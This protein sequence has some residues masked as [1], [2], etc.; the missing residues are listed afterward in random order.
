MSFK[1]LLNG[2]G[3][4]DQRW[5][6]ITGHR[7]SPIVEIM[8]VTVLTCGTP[9]VPVMDIGTTTLVKMQEGSCVKKIKVTGI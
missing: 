6:T 1:A 4:M 8:P 2:N 3:L 7:V 5:I 9:V